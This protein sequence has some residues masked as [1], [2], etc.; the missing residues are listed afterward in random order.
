M[1]QN[2]RLTQ[3]LEYLSGERAYSPH[4]LDAY[5]SDLEQFQR[6]L[7]KDLLQATADDI[8]G[9]IARYLE[10]SGGPV[11]AGRKLSAIR[12]FY[13]FLFME[14]TIPANPARNIRAPK[15]P[16]TVLRPTTHK[17]VE[18]L[19]AALSPNTTMG[20]RDRAMV[21]LAYGSG[22]RVSEI[23][24]L[25][26]PD[27]DFDRGIVK[28]KLGKGRKDRLAPMN[29]REIIAIARYV[30][31]ARP[32]LSPAANENVVFLGRGGEQLSRQRLWQ[33]FSEISEAALG[34]PVSPHKFRHAFVSDTVNGGADI[35]VVQA[36]AG[37]S[38][39]KTT[40]RYLH[41]DLERLRREY[42]KSH[43]RGA[44]I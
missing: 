1:M 3:F 44:E 33:V 9:F 8:C 37:H 16:Q 17:E 14:G 41:C 4:T 42:L 12:S 35:R 25:R 19:L 6:I 43:P 39:I 21:Y 29:N 10:D 32:K 11:S 31:E 40:Q 28:V 20:L 15:A 23:A 34:R 7:G 24:K 27:L 38:S 13:Q 2:D 30:E 26:I 18:T 22:L 36:M 5:K